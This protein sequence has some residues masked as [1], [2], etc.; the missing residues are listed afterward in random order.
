VFLVHLGYA[1]QQLERHADAAE[2]FGKAGGLSPEPDPALLEHRIDALVQA[3]D[4]ER[5]AREIRSARERFPKE[6]DLA[7]LE[8]TILREQGDVKGTLAIIDKLRADSP[9]DVDVLVQVADFYQKSKRHKEAEGALREALAKDPK[10]LRVLFLLGASLERQGRDDEAEAVFREAL[11]VQPDFPPVLNYLGYMNAD[12][13][14]RLEE[15]HALLEKAVALDPENGAYLDSLGW[16]STASTAWTRPRSH[17]ARPWRS[18]PMR[19]WCSPTSPTPWRAAAPS[20]RPSRSGARPWRARTT[21][22]SWTG[23]RSRRRSARPS[24]PSTP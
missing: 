5:A 13:G 24:R 14:V 22:A 20:R 17:P 11:L 3:K 7:A 1:Y 19:P 10:S 23:T 4:L 18:S 9:G 12:R 15:S 2:A 16:A 6:P 21:T 8:A